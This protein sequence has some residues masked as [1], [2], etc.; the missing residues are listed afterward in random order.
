M[1]RHHLPTCSLIRWP[2]NQSKF[3]WTY[4]YC[5]TKSPYVSLSTNL[6]NTHL[7]T[8]T[9]H[10]TALSFPMWKYRSCKCLYS[11]DI[12]AHP[13]MLMSVL[14]TNKC[15]DCFV[16]SATF[17][18]LSGILLWMGHLSLSN[19]TAIKISCLIWD[20]RVLFLSF[21][22]DSDLK[23]SWLKLTRVKFHWKGFFSGFFHL[24]HRLMSVEDTR[25]IRKVYKKSSNIDPLLFKNTLLKELR[26]RN[27]LTVHVCFLWFQ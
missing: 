1:F 6:Y 7:G 14:V 17:N 25:I 9:I 20:F 12:S 2:V 21:V 8:V 16:Y 24:F 27:F 15:G 23:C 11:L 10:I 5:I 26:D 13:I 18:N 19:L 3:F 22:S 4:F